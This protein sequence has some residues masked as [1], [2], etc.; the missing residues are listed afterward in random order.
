MNK[1]LKDVTE[2]T[3]KEQDNMGKEADLNNDH[4]ELLEWR[5]ESL[6]IESMKNMNN[7]VSRMKS[8]RR[9]LRYIFF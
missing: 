4:M 7:M 8:R 3:R 9:I 1:K 2:T 5:I 6:K